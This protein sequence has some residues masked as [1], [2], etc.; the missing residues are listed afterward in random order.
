MTRDPSL[1]DHPKGRAIVTFGRSW[2]SLAVVRSLAARGIEVI[3]ADVYGLTVGALSKDSV[4]SFTYPDPADDAEGFL[5]T[6]EQ[7]I[8]SHRPPEGVPYVLLP[9]QQ[10][11]YLISD[12]RERFEDHI[13]LAL[14]PRDLIHKVRDKGHLAR[15]AEEIGLRI[16]PTWTF[17][18]APTDEELAEISMPVIVKI[19]RGAGGTGIE[20]VESAEELPRVFAHLHETHGSLPLIQG[21]SE[22][23]DL[24]VS[25]VC[26]HGE[27]HSI[28]TYQN[29]H[30]PSA[31]APGSVRETIAAPE[32]EDAARKL[33]GELGWHGVAQVDFLW[34]GKSEPTL[35]EINPR[36][37]G[38]LFQNVA[39]GIDIPW[40]LFCLAAGKPLP[41][42]QEPELGVRTETPFVGLLG[43]LR[44]LTRDG[45]DESLLE[46]LSDAWK[47]TRDQPD[48]S[49]S[50]RL[51]TFFGRAADILDPEDRWHKLQDLLDQNEENISQLMFEEDPTAALG[52]LYP[53]AIFM[54]HGK[55]DGTLLHGSAVE[56][57]GS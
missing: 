8:E 33:L 52:L 36:L 34:D 35:I 32:A 51:G 46:Q 23:E 49:L 13:G 55:I 12:H 56:D 48:R 25:A 29:R 5:A 38:G 7:E 21:I 39:S 53:M 1:P 17:E 42:S 16:P 31:S 6:L 22:G 24:C 11:T 27:V 45:E 26:H 44:E 4:A 20:R 10:E 2:H 28:M 19:P 3:S 50:H 14:P 30:K 57:P 47:T 41:P 18:Q 40:L 9:V 43:I 37:F 15:F 54:K